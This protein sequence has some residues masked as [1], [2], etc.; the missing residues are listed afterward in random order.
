[1]HTS[2]LSYVTRQVQGRR[3]APLK[4]LDL[5]ALDV[6]GTVRHLFT[7]E[8]V[9]VDMIGGPN[10]DVVANGHHLP[11]EDASFDVVVCMEMFEHD[12]EF[13][14]SLAEIGRVLR[15]GGWFLF[16]TRGN[17]FGYHPH[18]QDFYRFMPDAMPKL[19]DLASCEVVHKM[20][21]E[22]EKDIMGIGNR[23]A[24]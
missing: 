2:V 22:G 18:P 15:D 11:F 21:D 7:G 4:T 5:G 24:R 13:W 9:G 14:T 3:L 1:M 6:N 19:L 10:V 12:D 8:Y 20:W 23:R 17:G 16:T